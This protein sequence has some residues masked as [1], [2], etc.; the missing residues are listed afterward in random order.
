MRKLGIT[1]SEI[2]VEPS[3]DPEAGHAHALKSEVGSSGVGVALYDNVYRE[4]SPPGRNTVNLMTLQGYGP[5]ERFEKA[6]FAGNKGGYR[7]EKERMADILIQN[8]EKALLP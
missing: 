8:A 5:W 2:F 1:D 4:Y 3:Y 6:Y 7:K